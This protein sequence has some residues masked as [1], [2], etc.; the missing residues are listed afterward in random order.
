MPLSQQKSL[1]ASILFQT[2]TPKHLFSFTG[3]DYQCHL[4]SDSVKPKSLLFIKKPTLTSFSSYIQ[5]YNFAQ[6]VLFNMLTIT[7]HEKNVL[8]RI[9][10]IG[11]K[12]GKISRAKF[13]QHSSFAEL[14]QF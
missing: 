2:S 6:D 5:T 10:S 1:K 8:P 12:A 9:T 4:V 3:T 7:S 13:S 14:E 11:K